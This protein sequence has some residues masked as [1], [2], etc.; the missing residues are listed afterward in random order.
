MIGPFVDYFIL[1]FV[2]SVGAIQVAA[3]WSGLRG[4]MF[5]GSRAVSTLGGAG[6]AVGV[7]LW[8]TLSTERNLP[9]TGGGLSGNQSAWLFSAAASAAIAFSLVG[10]SL[11]NWRLGSKGEAY[12]PGLDALRRTTFLRAIALT[13]RGVWKRS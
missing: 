9:D 5:L 10:T 2:A 7:L 1:A 12:E 4:M 11:V 6:M 3:A 8:Y 13:L